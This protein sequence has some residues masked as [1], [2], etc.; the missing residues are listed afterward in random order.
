M[1]PTKRYATARIHR[2]VPL[3]IQFFL[4]A[5]IDR[6]QGEV[7]YLQVFEL[8]VDNGRQKIVHKQVEPQYKREYY[9]PCE[10]ALTAKIF[11]INDDIYATMLF[12]DEY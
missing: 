11:V 12:A 3:M 7:D 2:E 5:C 8:S 9:L 4:W 6:L 1:F 10:Q